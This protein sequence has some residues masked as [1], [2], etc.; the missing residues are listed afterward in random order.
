M[1]HDKVKLAGSN[2][3]VIARANICC[4]W[5][6]QRAFIIINENSNIK[7][8]QERF[9]DC[10]SDEWHAMCYVANSRAAVQQRS[11]QA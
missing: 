6:R 4:H 2:P 5:I 9:K 11:G 7:V 10:L 8:G 3:T 1:Q